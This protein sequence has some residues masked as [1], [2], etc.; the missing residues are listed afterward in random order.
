MECDA[1]KR[2]T[3]SAKKLPHG[4]QKK[5]VIPEAVVEVVVAVA[6]GAQAGVAKAVVVPAAL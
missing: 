5:V 2:R 4:M 1:R 3:E 6:V